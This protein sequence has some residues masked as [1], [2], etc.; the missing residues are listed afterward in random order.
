M[1]PIKAVL[2]VLCRQRQRGKVLVEL[3]RSNDRSRMQ[4]IG[5]DQVG[6]ETGS[7]GNRRGS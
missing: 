7:S 3:L 2:L 5:R 4:R 6:A 1:I